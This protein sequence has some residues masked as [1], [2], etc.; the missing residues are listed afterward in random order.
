MVRQK[1]HFPTKKILIIVGYSCAGK[2]VLAQFVSKQLNALHIEASD[3]MRLAYSEAQSELTTNSLEEFALNSLVQQPEMV[4]EKIVTELIRLGYPEDILITGF[5]SP[6][7]VAFLKDKLFDFYQ[8]NVIQINANFESRFQRALNR[9]REGDAIKDRNAFL[10]KDNFH[11]KMG[12]NLFNSLEID[13]E[14][15]LESF[16]ATFNLVNSKFKLI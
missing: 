14:G 12:V 3:F 4:A 1:K 7:E 8:V 16:F 2:T 15:T 5:R 6:K 10:E 9:N 13:N 11:R